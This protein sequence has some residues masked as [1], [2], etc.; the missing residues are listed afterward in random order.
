MPMTIHTLFDPDTDVWGRP[1]LPGDPHRQACSRR[2]AHT[3]PPGSASAYDSSAPSQI[4]SRTR[5]P[6]STL[7]ALAALPSPSPES[8][9]PG[10]PSTWAPFSDDLCASTSMSLASPHRPRWRRWHW[11]SCVDEAGAR[12]ARASRS[13]RATSHQAR[14]TTLEMRYKR[15]ASAGFGISTGMDPD[16]LAVSADGARGAKRLTREAGV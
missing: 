15:C 7:R 11:R 5:S 2:S 1:Q 10:D 14:R 6:D 8:V 13:S 16:W 3:P 12:F 4:V 9:H